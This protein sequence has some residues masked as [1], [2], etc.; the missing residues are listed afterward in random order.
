MEKI[1]SFFFPQL[2]AIVVDVEGDQ[3]WVVF[4]LLKKD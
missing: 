1:E 3:S 2:W 4:W